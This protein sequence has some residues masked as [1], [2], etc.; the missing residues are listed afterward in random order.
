M[1]VTYGKALW[2]YEQMC[3]EQRVDASS[4]ITLMTLNTFVPENY[5]LRLHIHVCTT[6][7]AVFFRQSFHYSFGSFVV[8]FLFF[9]VF[10]ILLLIACPV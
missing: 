2:D 8:V 6:K 4:I 5:S 9:F 1:V 10:L 7:L 3:S